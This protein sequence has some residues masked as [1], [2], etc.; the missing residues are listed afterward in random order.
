MK[1]YSILFLVCFLS[2]KAQIID[3][4]NPDNLGSFINGAY[5]K[6]VTNFRDQFVGTWLYTNG[7]TS[8]TI[9]LGKRD[10]LFDPGYNIHED[11][12]VGAYK[13]IENGV[14]KV[15]TLYQI[16]Q[17]YGNNISAYAANFY[18]YGDYFKP[19]PT[20]TPVC[21]EC[22]VD[23]RRMLFSL[24]EPDKIPFGLGDHC[25][26]IRRFTENGVDKIKVWSYDYG[27]SLVLV[28]ENDNPIQTQIPNKLPLGEFILI[29]Q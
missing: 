13:Y 23:E 22:N 1:N 7:N 15:N 9:M 4:Y 21:S 5:Y 16:D 17:S 24:A 18:L 20:N 6:D 11:I 28:D 8:L 3:K 10:Y 14:E 19:Y 27:N 29:K 25:L 2:C 12:M 26:I